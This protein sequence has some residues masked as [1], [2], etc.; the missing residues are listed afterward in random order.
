MSRANPVKNRYPKRMLNMNAQSRWIVPSTLC[1][2][3][4]SNLPRPGNSMPE[5]RNYARFMFL[6]Y[7]HISQDKHSY[8]YTLRSK[9]EPSSQSKLA[10]CLACEYFTLYIVIMDPFVPTNVTCISPRVTRLNMRPRSENGYRA[11][12]PRSDSV[13]P[14]LL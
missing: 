11:L 8:S 3:L 6:S 14:L 5:L 1:S 13:Q 10:Q 9:H 4:D 12:D 7:L 2:D